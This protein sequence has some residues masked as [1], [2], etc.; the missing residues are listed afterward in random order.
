MTSMPQRSHAVIRRLGIG[1]L[2]LTAGALVVFLAGLLYVTW[3]YGFPVKTVRMTSGNAGPFVIG[4]TKEA[5]LATM[6]G[7][8]FSPRPKPPACPVNWIAVSRMTDTERI[9]L[10]QTDTWAEGVTYSR[11]V[12]PDN[13]DMFTSLD[14]KNGRLLSVTTVCR[15]P[16]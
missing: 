12:C 16:K 8:E 10:L 2:L 3:W 7:E 6:A 15:H 5:I 1:V 4:Q 11:S 9:C 13:L 14:F